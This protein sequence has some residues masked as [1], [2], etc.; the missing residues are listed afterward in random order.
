MLKFRRL[1][2][3][4]DSLISTRF[5]SVSILNYSVGYLTFAASWGLL[6]DLLEFWQIA[7]IS[8]LLSSI[9]SH[10]TQNRLILQRGGPIAIINPWYILLQFIG[11]LSSIVLV[12]SSAEI[13][14]LNILFVQFIWSAFFSIFVFLT[15]LFKKN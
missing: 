15:L 3:I 9:F 10:Q 8:T 12:P 7:C 1:K 2:K 6:S 14:S 13:F 11:L 4:C 5:L